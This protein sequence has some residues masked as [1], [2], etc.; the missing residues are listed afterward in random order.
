M[1]SPA[2]TSPRSWLDAALPAALTGHERHRARFLV[3]AGVLLLLG[4]AVGGAYIAST[5]QTGSTL[6]VALAAALPAGSLVGVRRGG[7][8]RGQR[9]GC[10]CCCCSKFCC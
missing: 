9:G 7:W 4:Y 8:G 1:T 2:S 10:C 6:L 5:G 3:G